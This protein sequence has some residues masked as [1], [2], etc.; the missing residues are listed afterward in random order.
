MLLWR[1]KMEE[2]HLMTRSITPYIMLFARSVV[3]PLRSRTVRH[4]P[5]PAPNRFVSPS[6]GMQRGERWPWI[7]R[8]EGVGTRDDRPSFFEPS[9]TERT[10]SRRAGMEKA[11]SI[12]I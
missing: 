6:H 1:I 11:N 12:G 8:D 10:C 9:C 5:S 7:E 4:R 3:G 2:E